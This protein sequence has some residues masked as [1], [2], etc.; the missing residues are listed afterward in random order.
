MLQ[1]QFGASLKIKTCK[2]ITEKYYCFMRI[3]I[4][5]FLSINLFSEEYKWV[6]DIINIDP[7]KFNYKEGSDK[8]LEL[9]TKSL[10]V[11]GIKISPDGKSIAIQSDS[12]E[13]TQGII[14]SDFD[15]FLETGIEES[16]VAK[17]AIDNSKGDSDLGVSQLFLCNF[18]WASSE[19]ILIELCGKRYDFIEGEIFFSLGVYR[20]FNLVTKEFKPFL[21]PYD[22]VAK[23][24]TQGLADLY[25]PAT[26]ISRYDDEHA[27]FSISENKRG[28]RYAH[29]RKIK[30]DKKGTSP[31]GEDIYVS[32]APCQFK[33]KF[34]STNYCDQSSIFVLDENKK[35]VLTFSNDNENIYAH[36]A[37]N[38]TT[39]I[40]IELEE[41]GILGF[42]D[43]N[44]WLSGD[45]SGNS[46][47]V[48]I[49]DI[50]TN[51]IRAISPKECH[52]LLN[53]YF[54]VNGS[55]PYASMMECDG[56]KDVV[57]FD[58]DIRDAQILSSLSASF[59]DKNLSFGG[60]TENND[61]ALLQ[62]SDS[63]SIAD[64]FVLDL[65]EGK[66]KYLTT[67]SNVPKEL[68][69]KNES[70]KFISRDGESIFGYFT[71]P[72]GK[73][74]KLFVYVHGGPYGPR[75]YD[76]YDPFEQ[77]LASQ[78]IAVLKVNFRGSGGY[79]KNFMEKAYKEWGGM[80][81]DDIA[82]ATKQIQ[83]EYGL[84]R[85]DTCAGG[86]SFG[87]YAA[88]AMSYKYNDIYECVLGMMGVFDLKMLRDGT[89]GSIYTYQDDYDELMEDYLGNDEEKLID[90][91]PVFN[92][93]KIDTRVMMW[94]GLQDNIT[95]IVHLKNMK[96]ALD[97]QG[98]KYH[99][100]TMTRLGHEYGEGEDMRAMFPVMKDYILNEL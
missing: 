53:Y 34:R 86:A 71:K 24:T 76:S 23:K 44:L 35:P 51:K 75:D 26:F 7:E 14:I 9:Y 89:D 30:L 81:M 65:S 12:E 1:K 67:A 64:F 59:K 88:L 21:Y 20:I 16:A 61:K 50:Q 2:K 55:S 15:K 11:S 54:T 42:S 78:G 99:A 58:P 10:F 49:L 56:K 93:S 32:K 36:L 5:L 97:E 43:N 83:D 47:G 6:Q 27:L 37:D 95:P 18:E 52:S 8:N 69:H 13:F 92:A 72:K 90:F 96:N 70:R 45:P 3:L 48:S 87:G 40:D 100:F 82:D 63:S 17:I 39:K 77:Y 28:F 29:L 4:I 98:K 94:T 68:L 31:I 84:S 33:L 57:F 38:K 62:V 60:W 79:G 25:R 74:K 41:Y 73:I 85:N 22:S 91:S 19:K 46:N 66:L 80:I